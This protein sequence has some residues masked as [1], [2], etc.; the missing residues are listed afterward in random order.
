MKHSHPIQQTSYL[1]TECVTAFPTQL[2]DFVGKWQ[3]SRTIVQ[4]NGDTFLFDGS[5]D[6][7][8]HDGQLLYQESGQVKAPNGNVLLAERTYIWQAALNN[9]FDVLFDD[10]RYFHTFSAAKPYG[11]HLCGNDHY[12]VNYTFTRWPAWTSTWQVKGPRK[13]YQMNSRYQRP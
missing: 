1:D 9:Q 13:D 10:K 8:W 4:K 11:E 6:F 5:A 3:L 12:V 2:S 7:T